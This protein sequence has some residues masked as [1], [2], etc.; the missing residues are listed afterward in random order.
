MNTDTISRIRALLAAY[1]AGETSESDERELHR[2]LGDASLPAEFEE[3]RRMI[4]AMSLL[5]PFEGFEKRLSD[6]IDQ[7]AAV[8]NLIG[9]LPD[10]Q[11]QVI[12]MHDVDGYPKEEIE[13][14]TG[15]SADNVR[16]LLSRAR[17]FIR[18]HF[19]KD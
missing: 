2:L 18:N 1:Y 10:R 13:R 7:M 11:R 15:L 6:K 5:A 16:Q 9:E 8:M 17:R 14:V 4:S 12:L 3:E 19:S